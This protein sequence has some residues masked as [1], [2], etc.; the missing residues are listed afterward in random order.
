M[1]LVT[2]TVVVDYNDDLPGVSKSVIMASEKGSG[3]Y[4]KAAKPIATGDIVSYEEP[5]VSALL[6][7]KHGTHCLHCYRR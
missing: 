1:Y 3:R 5:V 2:D 7:D 6:F 4:F